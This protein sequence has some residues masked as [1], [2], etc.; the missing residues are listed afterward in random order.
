CA[1]ARTSA[2]RPRK[3]APRSAPTSAPSKHPTTTRPTSTPV[4][5]R[6]TETSPSSWRTPEAPNDHLPSVDRRRNLRGAVGNAARVR[7]RDE[8][9]RAG[10]GGTP[11]GAGG[12]QQE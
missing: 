10:R 4:P 12:G 2:S 6:V 8:R 5:R 1:T 3:S 9:W 7:H 11:V